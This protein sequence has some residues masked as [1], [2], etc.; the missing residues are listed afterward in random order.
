MDMGKFD[1]DM[2]QNCFSST[3]KSIV[4]CYVMIS[5][6]FFIAFYS[7]LIGKK[8]E[9]LLACLLKFYIC[10]RYNL[11]QSQDITFSTSVF[12]LSETAVGQCCG[13]ASPG[14]TANWLAL[15]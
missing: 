9:I 11:D 12:M 4:A 13:I 8:R 15:I 10:Y 14:Q 7:S 2:L 1:C 5:G 6:V 3:V